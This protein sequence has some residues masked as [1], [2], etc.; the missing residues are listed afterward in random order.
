MQNQEPAIVFDQERAT[1]YDKQV[2]KLAPMR[3]ALHF[4]IRMV[5]SELPVD[6]RILCIGAGT[7][8]EL[9]DLAQAFPQWRFTAVEPAAPMLDICR[10]RAEDCGVA[11]RCT[12][13]EGYL[14]SLP[15][16][17]FFDGATCILVSQFLMRPEERRNL[18]RQI[19]AR[20]RPDGCLVSAD[21]ASDMST[22][23]YKN[24]FEVWARTMRYSEMPAEE[25]EKR[26]ASCGRDVAVL[27]PSE[28]ES[29]I[30]S[31]GFNVPVL[32]FQTLLIH[33]WYS[34][35]AS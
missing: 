16:L 13:H 12:F 6:A 27:P 7:G 34:K 33:A 14:D 17:G 9:I 32:F 30:A 23:A 29:I 18:F 26:L 19:A 15:E 2:G 11:S 21:L 10:Q 4:L 22:S 35:L 31:S 3:D 28:I 1:S 25:L 8:A 20:L 24:L 5:L